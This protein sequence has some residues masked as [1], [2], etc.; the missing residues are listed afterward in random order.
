MCQVATECTSQALGWLS[1]VQAKSGL[2]RTAIILLFSLKTCSPCGSQCC[3]LLFPGQSTSTQEHSCR[4]RT[5]KKHSRRFCC[6]HRRLHIYVSF[7]E[8]IKQYILLARL[9][10]ITYI[11]ILNF[12]SKRIFKGLNPDN[13]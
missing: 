6:W 9:N 7:L 1:L 5:K 11:I 4:S 3:G 2:E 12:E 8:L 10:F 13:C